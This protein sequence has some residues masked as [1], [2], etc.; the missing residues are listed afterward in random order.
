MY[1]QR[2]LSRLEPVGTAVIIETEAD[3]EPVAQLSTG[4]IIGYSERL[5]PLV[6]G[7]DG[8]PNG[9]GTS[10]STTLVLLPVVQLG[11]GTGQKRL[12]VV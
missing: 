11:A 7:L 4:F 6:L 5:L 2:L 1:G 10:E 8:L 9:A 3:A 12:A